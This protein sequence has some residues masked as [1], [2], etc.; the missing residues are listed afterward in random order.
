VN[1]KVKILTFC[2]FRDP[3][4]FTE[5][6]ELQTSKSLKTIF[7]QTQGSNFEAKPMRTHFCPYKK[8]Q[9]FDW[10]KFVSNLLTDACSLKTK[11]IFNIEK[12][13]YKQ[14]SVSYGRNFL[15]P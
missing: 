2:L 4:V 10:L 14:M 8:T 6:F 13:S 5:K 9:V 3:F 7:V 15:R 12:K 1:Q 11:L